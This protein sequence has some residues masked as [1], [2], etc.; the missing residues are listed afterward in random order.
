MKFYPKIDINGDELTLT[1]QKKSGYYSVKK[2]DNYI[3]TIWRKEEVHYK[4]KIR[5]SSVDSI[6]KLVNNLR[7]TTIFESNPCIMS[8]GIH[9]ITIA[10]G[11]DTVKYELMNTFDITALKIATIINSYLS[12]QNRIWATE[13]LIKDSEDCW[14]EMRKRIESR[15]N[16]SDCD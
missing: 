4:I 15:L 5:S 6:I 16:D 7:D 3:D 12:D 2:Y 11:G 10:I 1:I 9:L 13:K 8:G 14:A